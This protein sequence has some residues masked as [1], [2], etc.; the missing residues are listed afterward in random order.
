MPRPDVSVERKDQILNAAAA[1]F[2]RLGFHEARMDDIVTEAGLS[3]GAIYWYFKSKDEIITALM[4]RMFS[5][6]IEALRRLEIAE[7][8]A[9][10]RLLSHISTMVET[11]TEMSNLISIIYEFY[12]TAVRSDEVRT[13]FRGYL[14]NYRDT[15]RVIVQQGIDRGEFIEVNAQQIAV[16]LYAL[17][18][19][20]L[21]LAMLD[22]TLDPRA[23][24]E[25]NARLLLSGLLR[26]P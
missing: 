11:F 7:G 2:S 15:F 6:D 22:T 8:T 19:G 18:D 25:P 17:I 23:Y 26:H 4:H 20:T 21:M 9:F 13:F 24:I 16:A 10:D 5:Q 3:K 12:V 1:V 14:M